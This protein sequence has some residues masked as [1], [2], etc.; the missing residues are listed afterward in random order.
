M[1][2]DSAH[3]VIEKRKKNREMHTPAQYIREARLKK[4]YKVH[5]VSHEF[6]KDYSELK[7]LSSIRPGVVA[8]DPQVVDIRGLQYL[9]NGTVNYKL[10]PTDV[11]QPLPML[12]SARRGPMMIATENNAMVTTF[13]FS[14]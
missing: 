6:F 11:W 8:G 5:Y 12:R 10:R 13:R 1:E 9:P 3:A 2:C 14:L 4:P 7:Y